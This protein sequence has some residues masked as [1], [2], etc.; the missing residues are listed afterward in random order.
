[1]QDGRSGIA[2][3]VPSQSLPTPAAA[4]RSSLAASSWGLPPTQLAFPTASHLLQYL[5]A[6]LQRSNPDSGAVTPAEA[7]SRNP[8]LRPQ[9]RRATDG[10]ALQSHSL[11]HQPR[12]ASS[13]LQIGSRSAR[14]LTRLSRAQQGAAGQL[15]CTVTEALL[16]NSA[17][18]TVVQLCTLNHQQ[19]SSRPM[20][21]GTSP[22][23]WL[24]EG[25]RTC[26]RGGPWSA[27]Q[28]ALTWRH[29]TAMQGDEHHCVSR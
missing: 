13:S 20:P 28:T 10:A 15:S 26:S 21:G 29:L 3:M 18:P 12:T 8:A 25:D 14:T 11:P 27:S 22:N 16:T 4:C 5:N 2:A 23:R 7:H 24:S 1:M 17:N 6:V 9:V 19:A